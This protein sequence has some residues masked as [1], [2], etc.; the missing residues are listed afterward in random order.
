LELVA[1]LCRSREA[2]KLEI[3]ALPHQ[4][5]VRGCQ[6]ARP[7]LRPADGTL[8]AALSRI[9]SRARWLVFFVEPDTHSREAQ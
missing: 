7:K 6:C 4:L 8:V 9:L 2:N 1:L 5:A 3:L